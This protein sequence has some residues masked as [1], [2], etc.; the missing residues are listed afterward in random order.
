MKKEINQLK[1]GSILTYIALFISTLIPLIYT[2]IMLKILG[3]AEYG[4]YSLSNSIISYLGLLTLGLSS[5]IIR[6]MM[7]YKA[8]NDKVMFERV[9]GLFFIIYS[10]IAIITCV[11]GFGLSLGSNMFFSKGLEQWEIKKLRI[12]III[13]T[14]NAAISLVSGACGS[15]V[16]CY[17]RYV[18]RKVVDLVFTVAAPIINL[19]MLYAGF[20]SV[21]MAVAGTM[22]AIITLILNIVYTKKVLNVHMRIKNPPV[23]LLKSIFSFTAFVFIGMIADLLYWS[24]DK[25]LIGALIGSTAVAVYNIGATFNSMLQNL[26]AAISGV[27]GPRVNSYVFEKRPMSELSD[28]MIRVG[29]VQ[30]LLISLVLS[31][32]VLFGKQFLNVWA[33]DEYSQ[34]YPI[35]LMTMFPLA[36]PLIQNVAFTAICAMKKHKF[37]SVLYA[38]LAVINVIGTYFLLKPMGIIGA[39]LCTCVVFIIGQGIIMNWYYYKKI[40]LDIPR[41]WKNIIKMTIVPVILSVAYKLVEHYALP[42]NVSLIGLLVEII[43]YTVVFAGCTWLFTMNNYEKNLVLDLVKKVLPKKVK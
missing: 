43:C 2:P 5:T 41:F 30:Y 42:K 24:T 23:E 20:A 22:C 21:G 38:I 34:A 3:Q 37:R 10:I 13:M 7:K 6:Y 40:G 33:G 27:F 8:N 1:A 4:L 19:I 18:F 32:F 15:A 28:L 16:L 9:M 25:V 26:A 12:L 31:G 17:E 35:A 36:V 14:V 39:A 29:R 11:V